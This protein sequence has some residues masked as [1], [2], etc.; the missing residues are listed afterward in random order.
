MS[1]P[2]SAT[3]DRGV[4]SFPRLRRALSSK[5]PF[6]EPTPEAP[7]RLYAGSSAPRCNDLNGS[8]RSAFLHSATAASG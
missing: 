3:V 6:L 1:A 8:R 7:R 2:A 5:S 4:A